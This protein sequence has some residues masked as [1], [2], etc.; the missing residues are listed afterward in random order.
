MLS[1]TAAIAALPKLFRPVRETATFGVATGVKAPVGLVKDGA[2][3]IWGRQL[4]P[5]LLLDPVQ[6]SPICSRKEKTTVQ[7]CRAASGSSG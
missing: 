6:S 1:R 2:N 5:V 4:R 7:P 3:L